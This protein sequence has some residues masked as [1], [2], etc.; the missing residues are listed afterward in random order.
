[1]DV[2]LQFRQKVKAFFV[3]NDIYMIPVV[4]FILTMG[5]LLT[6]NW[7]LGYRYVLMRWILVIL[8][9]LICSLLPWSG[10]TAVMAFYLL[11][12]TSALSWE[13]AAVLALLMFAAMIV[14][15]FFIPGGSILIILVPMAFYFKIPY[16][17]PLLAG[18]FGSALS[19]IPVGLGVVFY[20]TLL[21]IEQNA[22]VFLDPGTTILVRFQT[23]IAIVQHNREMFL[24]AGVFMVVALLVY[25]IHHLSMD[26]ARIVAVVAGGLV[27]ILGFLM[28]SMALR[29]IPTDVKMLISCV[30]CT[31]IAL[32]ITLWSV[33]LDY[34]HTEFLQYEDDEYVYYVKAIPKI[35]I[36]IRESRRRR[37]DDDEEEY[38][39]EEDD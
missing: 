20:Y 21:G 28:G 16:L 24:T 5:I 19:F 22:L 27:M 12:H 26:Y 30:V 25:G 34:N 36:Q 4:K 10:I 15:F 32:A 17:V 37:E 8:V 23:V 38:D 9:S 6:M 39:D 11:G 33:S 29:L 31:L 7:H 3:Q 14:H 35:Q 2:L 18:I 13:V 1:M